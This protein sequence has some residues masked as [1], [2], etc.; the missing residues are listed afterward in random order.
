MIYHDSCDFDVHF[1]SDR[2]ERS[3]DLNEDY[4]AS[5]STVD[6][7]WCKQEEKDTKDSKVVQ[8]RSG[9]LP[10]YSELS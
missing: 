9:C 6:V 3:I 4:I 2:S 1:P 8:S 7:F 10:L 5:H